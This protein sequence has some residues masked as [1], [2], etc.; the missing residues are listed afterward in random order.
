MDTASTAA[1]H[2]SFDAAHWPDRRALVDAVSQA[3]RRPFSMTVLA[4]GQPFHYRMDLCLFGATMI[5]GLSTSAIEVDIGPSHADEA[6]IVIELLDQGDGFRTEQGGQRVD[7]LP[8]EALISLGA[9]ARRN[10]TDGPLRVLILQMPMRR[11][12]HLF[13]A[14]AAYPM[15]RLPA[16][17]PGLATLHGYLRSVVDA[18][19]GGDAALWRLMAEQM[20]ALC[21]VLMGS[22]WPPGAATGPR[23]VSLAV[24]RIVALE[25]GDAQL[26]EHAVAARL[27]IS[28]SYL[29]RLFTTEG[30]FATYLRR[31]RLH[32]AHLMLRDPLS[33]GLRVIDIA[34]ECG[35]GDAS[36]FNRQ[37]R[38]QFGLTPTAVRDAARP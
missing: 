18:P 16:G 33:R 3:M 30:G 5:G 26:D 29:R 1:H 37:F 15:R 38:R 34:H 2:L 12:R 9:L 35:F 23:A 28:G 31:E 21:L 25:L 20:Q 14:E 19:Q 7:V 10:R 22:A 17:T 11:F 32:R 8:G 27:R 6:N 13:D 24:R 36:T 4:P